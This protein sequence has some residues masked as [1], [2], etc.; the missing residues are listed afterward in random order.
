MNKKI[1]VIVLAIIA[2]LMFGACFWSI[3][4]DIR[5]ENQVE[6]RENAVKARLKQIR[7][8]EDSYRMK[9]KHYCGDI[10]S[11]VDFVKNE[12]SIKDTQMDRELTDDEYE[13]LSKEIA[14]EGNY[15]DDEIKKMLPERA[16]KKGIL[17]ED[18]VWES[19]S[20]M[21]GLQNADSL[22]FVP[23][24]KENVIIDLRKRDV[25][26]LKTA[27]IT[28]LVEFRA[29]IDDYLDGLEQK[30]V[31]NLKHDRKDQGMEMQ[32]LWADLSEEEFDSVKA[33]LPTRSQ[34]DRWIGLRMGDVNDTSNKMDDNWKK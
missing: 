33:L 15:T 20:A 27:E 16:I 14:S 3:Y 18:T 7:D 24:G 17:H 11:L 23:C 34:E 1:I 8:A 21:I 5:F 12:K 2:V 13:A 29:N 32:S 25:L 22:K 4:S 19:V 9:Y 30:R 10:D 31:D 26:D 6:E 28:T